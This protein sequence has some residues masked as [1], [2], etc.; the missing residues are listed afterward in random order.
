MIFLELGNLHR[1]SSRL[2]DFSDIDFS[3]I[4]FS[5]IDLSDI[6]LSDIDFN[7]NYDI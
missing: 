2:F 3:D 6:D 1:D 5:D 7:Y 4:D